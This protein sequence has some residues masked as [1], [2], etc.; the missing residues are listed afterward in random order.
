MLAAVGQCAGIA[1]LYVASLYMWRNAGPRQDPQ[2]VKK[3]MVSVL[4]ASCLSWLPLAYACAGEV[5]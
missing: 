4:G 3:R 2:T 5:S 1:L